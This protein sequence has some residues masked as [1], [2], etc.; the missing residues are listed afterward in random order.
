MRLRNLSWPAVSH[1]CSRTCGV[2]VMRQRWPK[3]DVWG[4]GGCV[5]W[6]GSE[7]WFFYIC[8]T[9]GKDACLFFICVRGGSWLRGNRNSG[10]KKVSL[11]CQFTSKVKRIRWKSRI[12]VLMY[13]VVWQLTVILVV[14]D[15]NRWVIHSTST[16]TK[17]KNVWH[18]KFSLISEINLSNVMELWMQNYYLLINTYIK[19]I[20]L[21]IKKTLNT[22]PK[23]SKP[24]VDFDWHTFNSQTSAKNTTNS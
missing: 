17:Y 9:G 19:T 7:V 14:C 18:G 8:K 5:K 3:T 11:I 1:S 2:T 22:N 23:K 13:C 20:I 24:C 15:G 12:N 4:A 10:N 21:K 16:Q 6:E